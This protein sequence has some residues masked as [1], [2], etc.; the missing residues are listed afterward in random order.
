MML[1]ELVIQIMFDAYTIVCTVFCVAFPIDFIKHIYASP[2]FFF[3]N[4]MLVLRKI[5][6]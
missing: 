4:V 6:N 5:A 1:K 2:I 3:T